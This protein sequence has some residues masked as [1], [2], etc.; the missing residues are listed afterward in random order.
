MIPYYSYI[1]NIL[2]IVAFIADRFFRLR[3]VKEFREAKEAQIENLHEQL[4]SERHN[5]DVTITELHKKRYENLK[6]ILDEKELEINTAQAALLEMQIA[7]QDH[8]KQD[9]IIKQL[10][11]ETNRLERAKKSLEI[12]RNVLLMDYHPVPSMRER[13]KKDD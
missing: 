13:M 4:E 6:L 9:A 12:E 8:E 3:S 5:N 2:L 10:I 1:F 11:D 7:L